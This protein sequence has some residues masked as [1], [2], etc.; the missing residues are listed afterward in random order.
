MFLSSEQELCTYSLKVGAHSLCVEGGGPR[1]GFRT[2]KYG[3]GL[4]Y[5]LTHPNNFTDHCDKPAKPV[6]VAMIHE[7]GHKTG[8]QNSLNET[9][10]EQSSL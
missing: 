5:K 9:L 6:P 4:A 7:P 1:E 8:G 3:P 10:I 2:V